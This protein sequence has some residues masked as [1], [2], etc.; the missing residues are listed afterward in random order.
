MKDLIKN[1]KKFDDFIKIQLF[2]LFIITLSWSLVLPI[3]T[4]LQGLMWTTSMI[5]IYLILQK[6]SVFVMPYFKNSSLKISYS[7]LIALDFAYM[8]SMFIYFVNVELFI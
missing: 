1:Y 6:L 2:V 3:V 5:S 8:L 4:K 7:I